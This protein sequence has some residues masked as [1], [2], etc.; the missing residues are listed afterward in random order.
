MHAIFGGALRFSEALNTM[1]PQKS[2]CFIPYAAHGSARRGQ[3]PCSCLLIRRSLPETKTIFFTQRTVAR[4][5]QPT[6][7]IAADGFIT[8]TSGGGV[9]ASLDGR[10]SQAQNPLSAVRLRHSAG[11][12][13]HV[14]G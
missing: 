6:F 13:Q 3:C 2:H 5:T 10:P 11:N 9:P 7:A 12:G 8:Y 14:S 4:N 1:R